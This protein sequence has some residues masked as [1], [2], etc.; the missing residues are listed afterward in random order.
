MKTLIILLIYTVICVTGTAFALRNYGMD[1]SH[2]I[3]SLATF[4]ITLSIWELLMLLLFL[5]LTL[6][7][8]NIISYYFIFEIEWRNEL[9]RS[10]SFLILLIVRNLVPFFTVALVSFNGYRLVEELPFIFYIIW[11][12]V[13]YSF[14]LDYIVYFFNLGSEDVVTVKIF[15]WKFIIPFGHAFKF[16]TMLIWGLLAFFFYHKSNKRLIEQERIL[17]VAQRA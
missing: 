13:A 5:Y 10:L 16:M 2:V 12:L 3:L 6:L 8:I 14:F 9:Y 11:I 4:R 7:I 15:E 17:H 1:D